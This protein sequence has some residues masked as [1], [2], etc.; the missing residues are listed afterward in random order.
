[1]LAIDAEN[2]SS[3]NEGAAHRTDNTSASANDNAF[4]GYIWYLFLAT[5][6]ARSARVA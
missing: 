5:D 1:M 4:Q 6:A 3:G 2:T